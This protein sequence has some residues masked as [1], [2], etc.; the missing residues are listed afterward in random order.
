MQAH[1]YRSPLSAGWLQVSQRVMV[2]RIMLCLFTFG[3]SEV[4]AQQF[5]WTNYAGAPGGLGNANGLVDSARFSGLQAMATDG[6]G[7]LYVYDSEVIRKVTT[8]GQVTT[9]AGRFG[10]AGTADGEGATARFGESNSIAVDAVGNIYVA[11]YSYHT[12]RKI[13]SDGVVS[14]IAG[15]PGVQGSNDGVGTQASFYFPFGIAAAPDGTLY[16]ADTGNSVIRKITVQGVVSTVAGSKQSPGSSDGN[17]SSA[18]FSGPLALVVLS[19]GTLFVSDGIGTVIRKIDSQGLVTTLCGVSGQRGD[20]DGEGIDAR[21]QDVYNMTVGNGGALFAAC[22]GSHIIRRI[23]PQGV[24][25]TFAGLASVSGSSDGIGSAARFSQPSSIAADAQSNLYVGDSFNHLIRKITPSASV[26]TLAGKLANP[27][28]TDGAASGA[29][30]NYPEDIAVDRSGNVYIADTGNHVIRKITSTGLV[31]TLAG[32]AGAPGIVDGVGSAA[33]FKAPNGLTVDN[34]GVVYV[35]DTANHTIRK[36][37]PNGTV[38]TLAGTAGLIGSLGGSGSTARFNRPSD[39]AVSSSGNVYV[40]DT[41]NHLVRK[42]TA[43]GL[44]STLAGS[45]GIEGGQDGAGSDA[46]FNRP[47]GVAVDGG[48][49][50]Y[51]TGNRNGTVRKITPEGVVSTIAG[52]NYA[53]DHVDGLASEARF[54]LAKHLDI[55]GAGF[56][57]VADSSNQVIRKLSPAGIV[58]TIGG[59]VDTIGGVDGIGTSALFSN[60][61]GIAVGP[62]GV[63][64]VSDLG[65]NRISKGVPQS[66]LAGIL[67]FSAESLTTNSVVLK[68]AVDPNNADAKVSFE[69]GLTISFGNSVAPVD[70]VVS[71]DGSKAVSVTLTGLQPHKLYYFRARAASVQGASL[72]AAKSFTTLNSAPAAG[73]DSAVALPGGAVTIPVLDNDSDADGDTPLKLYALKTLPPASAGTAKILG[74][75]IVFTPAATF[76][77]TS[78]TY[79]VVDGFGGT[80]VG[81]VNVSL[82]ACSLSSNATSLAAAATSYS[83]DVQTE[84]PWAASEA[85]SWVSVAPTSGVGAGNVMVNVLANTSKVSR[86]GVVM[87]GGQAHA[88]I[89]AGTLGFS[90]DPP[91][92]I[93]VAM[94]SADYSLAV[95]ALMPAVKFVM[96]GQPSGLAI[97]PI[98]GVI[99][100]KPKAS[101][102]FKLLVTG[103]AATGAAT[104]ITVPL[105]VLPLPVGAVGTFHGP[106]ARD[107]IVTGGLG[108]RVELTTTVSGTF[109]GKVILGS[110]TY[111]FPVSAVLNASVGSDSPTASFAIA[112]PLPKQPLLITFSLDSANQALI[113]GKVKDGD[114][115]VSFS[116]WRKKWGA[117]DPVLLADLNRYVGRHSF[118]LNAPV[119]LPELPQGSGYGTLTVTATTGAVVVTG[120]LADNTAISSSTFCGPSGEVLVHQLLYGSKGVVL[121]VL[122][123]SPGTA[124]YV[125]AYAD[126]SLSGAIS[127]TRPPIVGRLYSGGFGPFDL[128]AV[129]GRYVAPAPATAIVM[130]ITDNLVDNNARLAF[131]GAE[132]VGTSPDIHFR[133]KASSVFVPPLALNNPR[134]TSLIITPSTGAFSGQ[135]TLSDSNVFVITAVRTAAY[136]GQIVRDG[137]GVTRGYGFFHLADLPSAA[138]Q[139]VNTTRQKAGLVVLEKSP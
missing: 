99:S 93:P 48:E 23:T 10:D 84:V 38:S 98:T 103:T 113:N 120:K 11:D 7:N 82:G 86:S 13:T 95:P 118:A 85:L 30:F 117:T 55:D 4:K 97:N 74:N 40:A 101:G 102:T 52:Q 27:G 59:S 66:T 22:P 122:S 90:I 62:Q 89:Q 70:P 76:A 126:S 50:V 78:F 47:W 80:G 29:R 131:S 129:G 71:G 127:W 77:G 135:F 56:I 109:T 36:I 128:S 53:F 132:V 57:Y 81:S 110:S 63:L 91:S 24:V 111:T 5:R 73:G 33:R 26:T 58:T 112:R 75:Q 35:A 108:G 107:S 8:Q 54:G 104:A 1:K 105:T 100:G 3:Y 83:L 79:T 96:S 34:A 121:G 124:T 39:I 18:K 94:V 61:S 16:V 88:I 60:V 64:Y 2:F 139:T 67:S 32:T 51:V 28:S 44:V 138:G 72:S 37:Q 69:Y 12:I 20:T 45:A 87:I 15:S 114:A 133:L 41:F 46:R 136:Y 106:V 6:S 68:A 19:D 115:E 92:S 49:N 137:D 21:L 65:N 25:T 119:G 42:I 134:K 43:D 31:T 14:T 130:G 17:G 123:M 9:L 116:G 125:P